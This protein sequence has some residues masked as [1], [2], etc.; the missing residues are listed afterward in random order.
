MPT[1][2]QTSIL[3]SEATIGWVRCFGG[4]FTAG[5]GFEVTSLHVYVSGTQ[6]SPF[7]IGLYEGGALAVGLDTADLIADSTELTHSGVDGEWV[8]Y[9]LP[10]AVALTNNE[11][12][13]L[14]VKGAT[15]D[16]NLRFSGSSGD[17]GD[18]QS[19]RGRY[20][21]SPDQSINSNV[22]FEDPASGTAGSFGNSWYS[23]Y[24]T[25]EAA[26][27]GNPWHYYAQQ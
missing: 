14:C 3:G 7:R 22:A 8:Q 15:Q 12:Y 16:V 11:N 23:A 19:A 10:S 6:E 24:F 13:W 26:V 9:N 17:S 1:F 20:N 2:G 21:A 27:A 18:W 5:A 4:Q 25:Y